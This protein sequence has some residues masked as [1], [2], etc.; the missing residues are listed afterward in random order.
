MPPEISGINVA[1]AVD[2]MRVDVKLAERRGGEEVVFRCRRC[3]R[4][5][6]LCY[7]IVGSFVLCT[8][9]YNRAGVEITLAGPPE[10]F[11]GLPQPVDNV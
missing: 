6:G 1:L 4:K 9:C 7:D 11:G 5:M 2:S 10:L 8:E 3:Q